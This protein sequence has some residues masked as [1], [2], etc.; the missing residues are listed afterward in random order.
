MA[1]NVNMTNGG[2]VACSGNFYASGGSAGV[3]N[4]YEDL[5][6]TFYPAVLGQKVQVTFTSFQTEAYDGLLIY[7][8][9]S[10]SAPMISSGLPVGSS[11]TFTPAGSFY[12]TTSPGTVISTADDG[13]LTFWFR[14]DVSVTFLGW[15]ATV[16]C[17]GPSTPLPLCLGNSLTFNGGVAFTPPTG[18]NVTVAGND[19]IH[20]FLASSTFAT[21]Q[22]IYARVLVVA[23]GGG[24][25][26]RHAGGGGAGGLLANNSFLINGNMAVTVGAGGAGG[27]SGNGTNGSNSILGNIVAIGGGGGSGNGT[28]GNSGGSGGGGSNGGGAGAGTA[29]QGNSGGSHAACCFAYGGGGGG[30]G[31]AAANVSGANGSAGGAGLS[32][33]ISG[34]AVTY[35]GGGGGGCDCASSYAG[36][37]GIGGAGGRNASI[38]G[39]PGVA[40]TGSGGGGGGANG[41]NSGIGGAGGSGIVI[42]RYTVPTWSSS[43]TAVA[44]VNQSGVVTS[45]SLGTTTISYTNSMGI[46]TSRV[47]NVTVPTIA[48][49]ATV[50]VGG[51]VTLTSPVGSTP[52][53]FTYTS[54]NSITIPQA[55]TAE[56]LVVAGGGGGGSRHGGGGGGGGVVYNNAL[57]IAAGTYAITIGAGGGAG[58]YAANTSHGGNVIGAGGK[59][60]NSSIGAL[61]TAIGGGG[62]KTYSGGNGDGGSGGGG[63]GTSTGASAATYR[64]GGAGTAGQGYAGGTGSTDYQSSGGGG[65][66]GGVG[67]NVSPAL[68]GLSAGGAGGIGFLSS[69][70]GVATYYGGG[71]GGGG[72]HANDGGARLGGVGGNGGG[73]HGG[74]NGSNTNQT[75]GAANTGGGGGGSRS[76]TNEIGSAGGSGI[77]I[78]KYNIP[79]PSGTWASSNT[80]VATVNATTGV[81]TGIANGMAVITYTSP[82]GCAVSTTIRV[83]LPTVPNVSASNPTICA[84]ATT[85][86]VA[87]GLAPGG[88]DISFSTASFS[89]VNVANTTAYNFAGSSTVEAW[90]NTTSSADQ[91]I[92]FNKENQYEAAV[93]PDGSLQWAYYT[94]T[95]PWFWVNTGYTVTYGQ[96]THVAFV[97]D[98]ASA[99]LHT[100]VNGSLIHTYSLTGTLVGGTESFKIGN[101]SSNSPFSGQIDN[102]RL[103]NTPRSQSDIVSNMHLEIP[104]SS[105]GLVALYPLNGNG[106]ATV[107]VNGALVNAGGATWATPTYYTYTWSGGT[108]LPAASTNETQTTGSISSIGVYNYSVVATSGGCSSLASAN[109]PVTVNQP[110][111]VPAGITGTTSICNG[112]STTLTVSGG[113]LGTGATVEWFS[114]SCGGTSVGTGNSITVSP[115]STTTY[116]VRYAGTCN[117]T[118][119]VV[120]TVNVDQ[121]SVA[122]TSITG[123][124][125]VCSGSSTTLTSS[126]GSLGTN[127]VDVWYT[128][129]CTDAFDASWNSQPYGTYQTTVNSV[130]NGV[131]NVTSTGNDPMLMMENIGTFN[132]N[133]YQYVNIRYRVVSGIAGNV[134][135]F[136]TNTVCAGACGQQMV[137]APLVSNGSWNT[138]SVPMASHAAWTSSDVKGWRFDW[139][140]NGGVTMDID[141]ISLSAG[142][143]IGSGP[144]I[145]VSPTSTTTYYT[146][147]KGA[148]NNTSCASQTVNLNPTVTAVINPGGRTVCR[149]ATTTIS[150]TVTN[151]TGAWSMVVNPGNVNV[152][153]TGSGFWSAEVIPYQG[154]GGTAQGIS[155]YFIN[156]LVD[157]TNGCATSFSTTIPRDTV[158]VQALPIILSLNTSASCDLRSSNN[159]VYFVDNFMLHAAVN[160]YTGGG[161]M[162]IT[163]VSTYHHATVPVYDNQS[164]L[165]RVT[166]ITPTN[167]APSRVRLYFTE[168]QFQ[169]LKLSN[170]LYASYTYANL[171]VSKFPG[172]ITAPSGTGVFILPTVTV[173]GVNPTTH[174]LEFDNSTYSTF[175]IHFD[176]NLISPLPIGLASFTAECEQG[177]VRLAWVTA[178]EINNEKFIVHRS[179]DMDHWEDVLTVPGA[180]ASNQFLTYEGIDQRPKHGVSYYRLT[181]RDYDGTSET[182]TPVSVA[183][184]ADGKGN[185]MV[186]YPNPADDRFTVSITLANACYDCG[187]EI[188]DMNGKRVVLRRI[189]ME[190]GDN[191]YTFDRGS[192]NPGQY[193]IQLKSGDFVVKPVKLIIK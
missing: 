190:E 71:G 141:F 83:G 123:T 77:V 139:A 179:T 173:G 80:G 47:V 155:Y 7:N 43:N 2:S 152:S 92:I 68:T 171:A 160:D 76:Y 170:P 70:S 55:V 140:T 54:N 162:G 175:F 132:P 177:Q 100:Y 176:N 95:T 90:I 15:I 45:V 115:T 9:N 142:P 51:N 67:G 12:G 119:C 4:N 62:G 184:Y 98:V 29:G 88:Q 20:T 46:T 93:F 11:A 16:S 125:T 127:A 146:K 130:T 108:N 33:N 8:G 72:T 107:G 185:S 133:I 40:N 3:Y 18:G 82:L 193:I 143:I 161:N 134:E 14:S 56:V 111:I 124:S 163:N 180:G 39:S 6:Y 145:T 149:G 75:A 19:Q 128:G 84:P 57:A 159:W 64:A 110:S 113:T 49:P 126:G 148:C 109:V 28:A 48:G 59:G 69:I 114:G 150:G 154:V 66:A 31:A 34:S 102:V 138:V 99:Q 144:S 22:A 101:R 37:S 129:S 174:Y 89:Y 96:W 122:P 165:Q 164:Y 178:S 27:A 5:V 120:A 166:T 44:T 73:G 38:N 105:T 94:S 25:G 86:L 158:I 135:I 118:A 168:A 81:V 151:A 32:N 97:H 157:G 24:G 91:K 13:S 167:N 60:G 1:Q 121:M 53:S 183:C 10:T 116:Y 23:G 169:A 30:A 42:I 192:M 156:A 85:N 58:N 36:G 131:I 63:T 78:I 104:T 52:Y 103:W 191:T 87:Q 112:N 187:I 61:V 186:V 188:T 35:A 117:I 79:D 26:M 153:G 17:T 106:N 74:D 137:S 41:G 172:N 189:N 21:T 50:C 147:K 182:F 181:Q 65:G 136:F